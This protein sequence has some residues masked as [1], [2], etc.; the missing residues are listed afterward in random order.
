MPQARQIEGPLEKY[1]AAR[2]AGWQERHFVLGDAVLSYFNPKARD[3]QTMFSLMD[4][5]GSGSLDMD[6]VFQLCEK[7]GKKYTDEE[8]E[9]V[10]A[11]MDED[12]SNA[13][14]ADEFVQWWSHHGG[15]KV[16]LPAGMAALV[17]KHAEVGLRGCRERGGASR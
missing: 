10:Q 2:G 12:G 11:Q 17:D 3:S 15:R 13:V 8:F 4:E 6:E 14:D 5:D 9:K 16:P 7:L 1:S